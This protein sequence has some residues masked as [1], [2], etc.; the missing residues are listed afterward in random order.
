MTTRRAFLQAIGRAGGYS[1]MYVA[2][3][4]LGLLAP[5]E[6]APATPFALPP[7]SGAGVKVGV[8]GGGIA[9]LVAAYEL[10]RAGYD[11]QLFEANTRVGGRVWTVRGGDTV[12]QIGRPDQHCDFDPGL[13]MNAGAGRL[14]THHHRMFGYAQ[15]FNVPLEVMVNV[16][17]S[18]S[19]DF[20]G[21]ITERQAVNDTR[22]ILAELLSKAISQGALD[23][24][25]SGV[26]RD[27]LLADL[28]AYGDLDKAGKFAGTERSGY[29]DLPGAYD[30]AGKRVAPLDLKAL[31]QR[32][33]WGAGLSFEEIFDQQ[34][35]MFEPVGGMD[36]IA[37]AIYEAVKPH[38][39][40]NTPVR[41][42]LRTTNGVILTVGDG[43]A[44]RNVD[45]D[46]VVCALPVSTL[47]RVDTDFTADRKAAIKRTKMEPSTKVA[48]E[49]RRF[50]EQDENIFGGIAWTAA[51]NEVVW[52]PS[53]G[54]NT[55]NGVLIGAYA[56]GF[57]SPEAAA[58]FSAMSAAERIAISTATIERLH[59]GRS[60]ELT[61]PITVGWA[62]TPWAEGIAVFWDEPRGADY[63]LLCT[64]EDRVVF[65]GEHLSYLPAWQEGAAA[66][67]QA[68]IGLLAQQA[69]DRATK[70]RASGGQA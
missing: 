23:Q 17:R 54:F 66:S 41:R 32:D 67:A 57:T 40:L 10:L 36:R 19:F 58:R 52:Y 69:S 13:Y 22:G 12:K 59:P 43:A 26:D 60:R 2:M 48:F 18:V 55:P 42:L 64:P 5:A 28:A 8:M 34:A 56:T 35:P 46:Y 31:T 27:K 65:A 25:L 29:T 39:S 37:Y 45:V 20:A 9:G 51:E 62:Q 49:S 44:T 33:F 61:K 24:Q 47:A 70:K 15:K 6:A 63:K 7:G 38:V 50:W 53:A 4:S 30:N 3:Q 68:A 11:V 1:A 21:E 14:P 16:N